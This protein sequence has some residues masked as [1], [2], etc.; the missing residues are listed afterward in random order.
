[1]KA[2]DQRNLNNL[3]HRYQSYDSAG[4]KYA[5]DVYFVT[6]HGV[7]QMKVQRDKGVDNFRQHIE[8]LMQ[9]FNDVATIIVTD[10]SGT[11][12]KAAELN[13]PVEIHLLDVKNIRNTPVIVQGATSQETPRQTGVEI[14]QGL[15]GLFAG[16]EF[17]GLGQIA[18]VA[19]MLDDKHTIDRLRER[20]EELRV[21]NEEFSRKSEEWQQK[22]ETLNSQHERL[23]DK[24]YDLEDELDGLR[25]RDQKND[26][27][28]SMIGLAGAS[29]AKNFIRQNPGILSGI[30]P[31]EQLAGIFADDEPAPTVEP[32]N[33]LSEEEQERMDDTNTV[34]EWLQTLDDEIFTQVISII[35]VLRQNT[36]YAAHILSFLNGK[37]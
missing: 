30:I 16:T 11:S 35:A 18:P 8:D 22:Y 1:M 19:K 28:I 27:W 20:N 5:F 15:A 23:Q 4:T 24:A 10:Y 36:D 3:Y 9:K 25:E 12:K 7:K 14:L 21:K 17:E 26:K 31:A 2:D 34:F 13:P 37:K 6:L 29:V 32:V 33:A